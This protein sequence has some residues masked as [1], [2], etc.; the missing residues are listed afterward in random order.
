M[1][2]CDCWIAIYWW[3]VQLICKRRTLWEAL[4]ILKIFTSNT[5]HLTS[6]II[7]RLVLNKQNKWL[8]FLTL[9]QPRIIERWILQVVIETVRRGIFEI[10]YILYNLNKTISLQPSPD[11]PSQR[12][13]AR[14]AKRE[15][16]RE[17]MMWSKKWTRMK[18]KG[19]RRRRKMEK[20]WEHHC[21]PPNIHPPSLIRQKK[22]NPFARDCAVF[23][24][25]KWRG[26]FFT[27]HFN[28]FDVVKT[29]NYLI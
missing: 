28:N 14:A 12:G 7:R 9:S 20:R 16:E 18:R 25:T 26:T 22:H 2:M 17:K 8:I 13:A 3:I 6:H 19:G 11:R 15:E 21:L 24:W 23:Y 5:Y 29:I 1:C 4:G 27:S 10:K